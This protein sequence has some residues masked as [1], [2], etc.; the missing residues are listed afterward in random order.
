MRSALMM[1]AMLALMA[2]GGDNVSHWI[3]SLPEPKPKGYGVHLSKA[4]RRGKSFSDLQA[5]REER[6]NA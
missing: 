5:L 6:K 3:P 1:T 4:E 2:H